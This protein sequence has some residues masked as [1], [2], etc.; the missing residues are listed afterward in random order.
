VLRSQTTMDL[1]RSDVHFMW[2]ESQTIGPSMSNAVEHRRSV[3]LHRLRMMIS[4][5]PLLAIAFIGTSTMAP[6]VAADS[7]FPTIDNQFSGGGPIGA[8]GTLELTVTGRGGVPVSGVGAVALNVTVTNPSAGSYLTVWPTGEARPTSSNLNFS[9]GQTVP[10][11]VIT[12]VGAG[13]R[14]SIFNFAGAADVIVDVLGWF[15]S[16]SGFAGLNPARLADSRVSPGSTPPAN[17]APLP[18]TDLVAQSSILFG[19][20]LDVT[21]TP[22]DS[23]GV[24]STHELLFREV[25][26]ST[27]SRYDEPPFAF[28]TGTLRATIPYS[29]GVR[30][31][32]KYEVVL[33][34][35]ANGL[36]SPSTTATGWVYEFTCTVQY[37]S[38]LSSSSKLYFSV[39]PTRDRNDAPPPLFT[40]FDFYVRLI[41]GSD[42]YTASGSTTRAFGGGA[43]LTK[44]SRLRVGD[45][46]AE[47]QLEGFSAAFWTSATPSCAVTFFLAR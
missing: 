10:N 38:F 34:L 29:A 16:S 21:W 8:G 33:T 5:L 36:R 19:P 46:S 11:M 32:R 42:G 40:T 1:P 35:I 39:E 43:S 31:G 45:H 15:P 44:P 23:A 2:K 25:G 12:K 6:P 41:V 14:V 4:V 30:S 17:R 37:S 24:N 22:R 27:W 13:G 20:A 47:V 9:A 18:P 26:S 7:A 3:G 28:T